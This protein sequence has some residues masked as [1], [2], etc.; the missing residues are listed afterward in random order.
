MPPL[1]CPSPTLLDQTFPRSFEELRRVG[2]A[3]GSLQEMLEN[4]SAHLVVTDSLADL[5]QLFDWQREDAQDEYPLLLTIFTL[6]TNWFLQQHERLVRIA[7]PPGLPFSPHPLPIGTDPRG[8][9]DDW[10]SEVGALLALHASIASQ[11]EFFIGIPCDSAFAGSAL[12][13]YSQSLAGAAFPLVGP[14]EA[15]SLSDAYEW[16][17]PAGIRDR[18]ISFKDAL[19]NCHCLGEATI[20]EP[21]GGSHYKVKFAGKARP[22]PLDRNVDPIPERFIR[23][24][25]QITGYPFEVVISALSSGTLPHRRPRLW[26]YIA[27]A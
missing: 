13:S 6:L 5:V 25:V 19:A 23:E 18:S 24:L 7:V 2:I 4:D 20:D 1:L 9:V 10:S 21:H 17:L 8:L 26:Q 22:W 27:I 3:F 15:V 14:R 11:G 12:G 16:A